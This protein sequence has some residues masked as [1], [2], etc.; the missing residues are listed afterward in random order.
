MKFLKIL[1]HKSYTHTQKILALFAI[2]LTIVSVA[3]L[4]FGYKIGHRQGV[5]S[6]YAANESDESQ[7][8]VSSLQV[9]SLKQQL[10]AVVQE[11]DISLSNL[12]NLREQSEKTKTENLQLKQLNTILMGEVVEKDGGLLKILAAEIEPLPEKTYEYRLDVA[13]IERTGRAVNVTTKLT[14]LNSTSQVDVPVKPVYDVKGMA[15]IRGKFVMP[16]NFEPSQ[17]KVEISADNKRVEALYNWTKGKAVA[18][19]ENKY[20]SER[21]IGSK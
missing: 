4:M 6:V 13:T 10:D 21:P 19:S 7:S 8:Q 3:T 17:M 20:A 15:Y 11:R 12:E 5:R 16:K 2:A 1:N 18:I 14:L 9:A